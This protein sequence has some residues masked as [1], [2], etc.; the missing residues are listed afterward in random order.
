MILYFGAYCIMVCNFVCLSAEFYLS[1]TGM[2]VLL[3]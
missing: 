1:S 3:K 2:D